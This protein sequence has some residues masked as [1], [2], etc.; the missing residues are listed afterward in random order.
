MAKGKQKK[1]K[2]G[3]GARFLIVLIVGAILG[4][5]LLFENK[6]NYALG[7]K[8]IEESAYSGPVA[9]DLTSVKVGEDLNVH[10][11]D[12]G[13]GDAC[14]IELPDDKNIIIDGG[15]KDA[16][17]H[18]LN[19]IATNIKNDDGTTIEFFDYAI[20][21][22]SDADHCGSLDEVLEQYPAK[23]FYR[24]NVLANKGDFVDPGASLLTA[25]CS[26]KD[27]TVYRDIIKIAHEKADKVFVN[28]Y[29]LDP[30][31][32]EGIEKGAEGY[33]SL[34][35]YG[36]NSTVYKDVNDYSPIM[37]LEYEGYRFS[38]TGDCEKEGEEEF[39]EKV[40]NASSD[41]KTDK[42]DD[43]NDNYFVDVIKLGHHGSR[44]STSP[45]FVEVISTNESVANTLLVISCGF[46]NKYKH[47]HEE[48]IDELIGTGFKKENML[49]TDENGDI[50]ISVRFDETSGQM[51]MFHG[52]SPMVKTQEK[53]IDWRYIAICIFGATVLILI[54]QPI[55]K[56]VERETKKAKRAQRRK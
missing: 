6:I 35:F 10:F 36:P 2:L 4:V 25:D 55:T 33:Y 42:F 14:I 22:H 51:R 28:S 52:A 38:L 31:A 19:Y 53:V 29:E 9:S 56:R 13:Q 37:I 17:E 20:L 12:V 41:G 44:T 26:S 39:V 40:E 8:S 54:V 15:D 24:P 21:T 27:T 5:S 23:V 48:K 45:E 34:S 18:L 3:W 43:F 16:S 30:I 32:P 47:P 1:M 50:V 46:D 49:R 7:L 11:V